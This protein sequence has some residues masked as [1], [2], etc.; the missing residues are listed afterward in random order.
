MTILYEL[1]DNFVDEF[2]H[3]KF[4]VS[5]G[6]DAAGFTY[7][8]KLALRCDT[9]IEIYSN[10]TLSYLKNR[11]STSKKVAIQGSVEDWITMRVLSSRHISQLPGNKK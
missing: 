11:Y 5:D 2:Q 6:F 4:W 3:Q 8:A 10:G 7:P 1:N 9:I